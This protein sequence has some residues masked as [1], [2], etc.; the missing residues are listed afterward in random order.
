[1]SPTLFAYYNN[2]AC[3]QKAAGNAALAKF[4]L[5][6][7]LTCFEDMG[8][9]SVDEHRV[10]TLYNLGLCFLHDDDFESAMLCFQ[11]TRPLYYNRPQ[12]WLRM[13]ECC[14]Q[15][16]HK[17]LQQKQNECCQSD[18]IRDDLSKIPGGR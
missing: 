2:L 17:L 14:I 5:I 13:A 12:L 6:R 9:S 15:H 8:I 10:K 4:F 1:M 18:L 11:E 3:V 16:Q 7:S